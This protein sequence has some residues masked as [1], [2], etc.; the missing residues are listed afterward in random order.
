MARRLLIGPG[1]TTMTTT[2]RFD[3][4]MINQRR[5]GFFNLAATLAFMGAFGASIAAMF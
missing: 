1:M 4:V 2:T 3:R 5:L